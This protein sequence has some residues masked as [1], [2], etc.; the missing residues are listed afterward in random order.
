[1]LFKR[2]IK[3]NPEVAEKDAIQGP[4]RGIRNKDPSFTIIKGKDERFD[5]SDLKETFDDI[6]Q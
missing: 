5:N 4:G 2:T 1:M 6:I 3:K